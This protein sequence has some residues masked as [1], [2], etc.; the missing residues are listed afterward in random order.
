MKANLVFNQEE[1]MATTYQR[2]KNKASCARLVE[3]LPS[4]LEFALKPQQ[5]KQGMAAHNPGTRR[6][7]TEDLKLKVI[8]D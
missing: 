4:M 5:H 1:K 3:V 6:A 7:E 2:Q 8:H